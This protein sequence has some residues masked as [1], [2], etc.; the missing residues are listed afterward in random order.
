MYMYMDVGTY[1]R[2]LGCAGKFQVTTKKK[3]QTCVGVGLSVRVI[4]WGHDD[5][6]SGYSLSYPIAKNKGNVSVIPV[7]KKTKI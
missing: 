3:W 7:E 6:D 4:R 5:Q 1:M 2:T